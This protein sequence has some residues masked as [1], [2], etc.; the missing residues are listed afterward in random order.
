MASSIF[1]TML[2][3]SSIFLPK[4]LA[5][6]PF[7]DEACSSTFEYF[8]R[9]ICLQILRSDP[10]ISSAT[11]LRDFSIRIIQSAIANATSTQ[12]YVLKAMQSSSMSG[13]H[14]T[15][16]ALQVC[17]QSYPAALVSLKSAL[18]EIVLINEYMTA[19]YDLLI[20]S[21]DDIVHCRD[22]VKAARVSDA[23]VLTGVRVLPIYGLSAYQIVDRL[24]A[25]SRS[26][27]PPPPGG[28]PPSPSSNV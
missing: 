18:N 20:A 1:I 26:P 23:V 4:I 25:E 19:S 2:F 3:I 9:D 13:D 21:T 11:T 17:S 28:L 15:A 8:D 27:P 5:D 10:Q 6:N 24:S 7:I 22:A 16:K 12:A 14:T